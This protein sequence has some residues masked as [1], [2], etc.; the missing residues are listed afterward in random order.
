MDISH[1]LLDRHLSHLGSRSLLSQKKSGTFVMSF[2]IP[3]MYSVTYIYHKNRPNVG[4]YAIH[5][6]YGFL[7]LRLHN[8]HYHLLPSNFASTTSLNSTSPTPK[9][10]IIR[11]PLVTQTPL[12]EVI[13]HWQGPYITL[14]NSQT[15]NTLQCLDA[16]ILVD[17]DGGWEDSVA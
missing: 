11:E 12:H 17:P 2:P 9:K 16:F 6:W 1:H 4:K 8:I 5:G 10:P 14:R 15:W 3:S 13:H 7:F